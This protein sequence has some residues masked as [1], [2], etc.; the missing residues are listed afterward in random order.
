MVRREELLLNFLTA[1]S[2]SRYADA[3]RIIGLLERRLRSKGEWGQGY[4]MALRGLLSARKANDRHAF[5][6]DLDE[7]P[8]VLR[9]LRREFGSH[10]RAKCHA[11][12]DRGYFTALRELVSVALKARR[13]QAQNQSTV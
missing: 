11:D 10:A 2:S 4:L 3:E 1:L 13:S 9:E 12:F 5:R 6:I 7:D 8:K